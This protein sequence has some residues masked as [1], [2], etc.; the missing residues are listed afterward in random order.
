M[1]TKLFTFSEKTKVDKTYLISEMRSMSAETGHSMLIQVH[2][3]VTIS[4]LPLSD[5]PRQKLYDYR[6]LYV[7]LL[8]RDS[9][10]NSYYATVNSCHF[11]SPI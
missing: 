8:Q 1:L 6:Y 4:N 9:C 5:K 11:V 10:N 7:S 3:M 2:Q